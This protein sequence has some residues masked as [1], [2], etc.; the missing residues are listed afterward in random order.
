[1][2]L[3]SILL[4]AV[5][6]G[7]A[8][9][10]AAA[11]TSRLFDDWSVLCD[12]ANYCA[13]SVAG[14]DEAGAARLAIAR[15]AEEIYWELSFTP[16]N[17]GDAWRELTMV[18]GTEATTFTGPAEIAAYGSADRYYLLG[19]KAQLVL[20]QLV[21]A[22]TAWVGR[23]DNRDDADGVQFSLRGLAAALIFIDEHQR[24][25]GSERVAFAPPIGLAPA[26]AGQQS[27]ACWL[28]P[29]CPPQPRSRPAQ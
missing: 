10:A 19:D 28:M 17:G 18:V 8:T 29:F 21:P 6:S 15:H 13:A 1:M 25:L 16:A 24:R 12:A 26:E 5:L 2:R 23:T 27:T 14:S 4:S 9:A 20:D 7:G 3:A 11:E 22:A